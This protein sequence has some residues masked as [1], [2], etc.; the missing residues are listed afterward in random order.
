MIIA[1]AD[2]RCPMFEKSMYDSWKIR[3]E[4]YIEN[5]EN[6]R[7]ILNFVLIG[8][9]VWPTIVEENGTN[10]TKKYEELSVAEK[11]QANCDLK[12]TNIVLQ[13][14]DLISCLN[15]AMAFISAVSAS[16]FPLTNNQLRT[17]SNLRNQ[18]NATSFE[19]NNVGG[20]ERVVKC[21]TCQSERHMA[22]KCTQ[23][24]RPRNAAWF[25]EKAMLTGDLDA[26]G[27][28]CDD[29]SNVKAVLMANL[30]NYSSDVILEVPHS[31]PYHYDMDNQNFGKR[32]V[33][34]HELSAEQA[35]WLQTS[36]PN[37]DQSDT[38]PVKIKAPKELLKSMENVDLKG[39]IQ[40]KVF[41]TTTFQ[42]ELRKLKGK[43]VLDNATT[44][45]NATTIAPGMFKLDLDPLAPRDT[46]PNAYK[47]SE[48]LVAVTPMNKVKK[49]RFSEPLTSSS[50]IHKQVESSKTPDSN[51][52]VF[53]STGLKSS[54]SASKS[55]PTGNKKNDK[56]SQTLSSNMKNK[57]EVQLRKIKSKSNK[58]NRIKD[59]ICDEN[60][61]HTMLNAISELIYVKCKQCML[62]ANHD[63]CFLNFVN[64]VN[65]LSKSKSVK[66][67]QQHNI[68]KPTGKSNKSSHQ[69]IAEDTNQ[70]K[71]YLLHMHLY[72]PM[73]VER[74]NGKKYILVIV[75]DYLRF[76]WVKFPR[77]KDEAPDA[78]IKCIKNIQVC[79]NATFSN[80]R[81]NNE[82]ESVNQTLQEFYENV[83]V[84][85]QT[86]VARTPQQ[87]G[88]VE[89]RNGTLVE[90]ARTIEDLGKL[91]SKADIGIFVGYA[92]T[93]KAFRIYNRRS[94]KIMETIHVMFDELTAMASE[95]FSSGPGLQV[96][97]PATF[98][99]RLVSNPI[100]QQPCNLP[101]KN[102]WDRL[103]QLMFD[104]YFNPPTSVVSPVPVPAAPRTV[105]IADL[106]VSTSIDQY[107]PSTNSTS[108]G[109]SSNVRPSH[110]PFELLSKW[111]KDHPIT[112]VIRDPSRSVSTRKEL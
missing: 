9:L 18:G 12:A 5:R 68:W 4:L 103:F 81:T 3:M 28:D 105:V 99:S 37:T 49:V 87:N 13:G 43:N 69:P 108:Q 50:N 8:P 35:Y 98:S 73:R 21:Y 86:S 62:D 93:K 61:K 58:K 32:F 109:S 10:R 20:H 83:G 27:S 71:L 16:R 70:E 55:Q 1:S 23:P 106:P 59:P 39:Q 2:N 51:T 47:P 53:P 40:E 64:D 44:I 107:A 90:V 25:K 82:T 33:L 100:P 101:T 77:L 26:Y 63:V 14:D 88:V 6:G 29:V 84:S 57:V 67:S 31:E 96:M 92:P 15:K 102:D 46:C 91:N 42:N 22:R 74:I 60:V 97:T 76:T 41:V 36:H 95:Q 66:Q 79:L 30:S 72:G 111:T 94:R 65:V 112:N 45:T 89:R 85:H 78:I 7:M 48:K 24:K 54:T 38:S 80:V 75:D 110:T 52:P 19:G 17:S 11:L 104:E 56:I 34:Q